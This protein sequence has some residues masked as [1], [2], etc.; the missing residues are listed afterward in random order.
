MHFPCASLIV[1]E[2]LCYYDCHP[3]DDTTV[4]WISCVQSPVRSTWKWMLGIQSFP[5]GCIAYFRGLYLL[6]FFRGGVSTFKLSNFRN[7]SQ[8]LS[9][10]TVQL[11]EN[12]SWTPNS[13]KLPNSRS[14]ENPRKFPDKNILRRS[15]ISTLKDLAL[16]CRKRSWNVV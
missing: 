2:K 6:G 4:S 13:L 10:Q 15:F 9:Q 1:P 7:V 16:I 14:S 5:F 12:F 8:H 3:L 11:P